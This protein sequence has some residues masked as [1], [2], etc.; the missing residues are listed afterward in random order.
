MGVY[1][2]TACKEGESAEGEGNNLRFAF[3][4]I[5]GWRKNMEDAHLTEPV[6]QHADKNISV[7]AVFDGHGG[8]EVSKFCQAHFIEELVAQPSYAQCDFETALR[9]NFHQMD[10]LLE[11]RKFAAELRKYSREP[12]PSDG[13]V[14][15]DRSTSSENSLTGENADGLDGPSGESNGKKKKLLKASDALK[16]FQRLILQEKVKR[17]Q[18]DGA[19]GSDPTDSSPSSEIDAED[20][21]EEGNSDYVPNPGPPSILSENGT[22]V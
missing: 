8:K 11:N 21:D 4:D 7:F 12:N 22:H 2:S 10:S 3:G 16:L 1:L 14:Q 13:L 20:D 18:G 9:E 6:V 5:Q 19:A 15:S 17:E